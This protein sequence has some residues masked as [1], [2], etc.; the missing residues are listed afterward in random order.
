MSPLG[1]E[2]ATVLKFREVA[3]PPEIE[4]YSL[5]ILVVAIIAITPFGVTPIIL[6]KFLLG[7]VSVYNIV[8]M[9]LSLTLYTLLTPTEAVP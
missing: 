9:P 6:T 4:T 8:L 1:R 2:L 7:A 5:P 3:T